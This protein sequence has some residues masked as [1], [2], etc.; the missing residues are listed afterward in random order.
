LTRIN[1]SLLPPSPFIAG[2]M[3]LAVS[4]TFSPSARGWKETEI[5]RPS[6]RGNRQPSKPSAGSKASR[7][8]KKRG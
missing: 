5:R 6:H 4:L 2:A 7:A 1:I 8:K 3:N